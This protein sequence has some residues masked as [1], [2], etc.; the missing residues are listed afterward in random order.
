MSRGGGI[1]VQ[2]ICKGEMPRSNAVPNSWNGPWY[3]PGSYFSSH[4]LAMFEGFDPDA[5]EDEARQRWGHTDA[6]AES[7]RRTRAYGADDWAAMRAESEQ[8][9]REFAA[10]MESGADPRG[11]EATALALRHRE[12]ISKWFYDCTPQIH[13]GLGE[14]YAADPRFAQNWDK[15]REGL[16]AF[17]RDAIS[18]AA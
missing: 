14:M 5:H 3:G 18:A 16:A 1:L 7:I 11:P 13:R 10:L 4:G 12:H 15:H 8:I 9:A 6:Y 17:V 2:P